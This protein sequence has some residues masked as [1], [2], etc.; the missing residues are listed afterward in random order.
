[1]KSHRWSLA[2]AFALSVATVPAFA[3]KLGDPAKPL[4]ISKWVKGEPVKLSDGKG[5]QIY[6]VE[7]WA[8]WCP[9]CRDSIPH[10]TELQKKYK[11]KGVTFI[12]IS[13]EKNAKTVERF[14]KSMGRKMDYTVA[15]D[16]NNATAKAYMTAFG[17]N[18]IPHAFIVDKAGKIVWHGLPLSAKFEAQLKAMT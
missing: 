16:K 17:V 5:K 18:T 7:F 13:T 10:L 4:Q 3:A 8:T 1:M 12:G 9:P 6:V 2:V 15:L 11:S 14:V